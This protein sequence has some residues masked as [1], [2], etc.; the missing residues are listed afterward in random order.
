MWGTNPV[1]NFCIELLDYVEK[2]NVQT[3]HECRKDC[4]FDLSSIC[5]NTIKIRN[6]FNIDNICTRQFCSQDRY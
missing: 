1:W 3:V 6:L 5:M 4:V 2:P